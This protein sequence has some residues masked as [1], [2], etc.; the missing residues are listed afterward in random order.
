MKNR[1]W[2]NLLGALNPFGVG[3]AKCNGFGLFGA[4]L[5]EYFQMAVAHRAHPNEAHADLVRHERT[6]P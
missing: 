6:L 5:V 2:C 1:L 4:L 3:C